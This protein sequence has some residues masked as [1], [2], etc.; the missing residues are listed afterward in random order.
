VAG[1]AVK[2]IEFEYL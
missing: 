2:K 1:A